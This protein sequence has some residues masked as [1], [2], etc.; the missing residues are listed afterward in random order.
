MG[1]IVIDNPSSK[2]RRYVLADE[3]VAET[4]IEDL[5][6][7]IKGNPGKLTRQQ[8]E[9]IQDGL[10]ADQSIRNSKGKTYSWEQV[11]KELGL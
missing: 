5:R 8:I 11:K 2:N 10:S 7:R 4:F 1:Q 3:T 9:D 6:S